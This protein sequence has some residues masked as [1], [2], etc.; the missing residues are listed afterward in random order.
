MLKVHFSI[1]GTVVKVIQMGEGRYLKIYLDES[2][3]DEEAHDSLNRWCKG[4]HHWWQLWRKKGCPWYCAVTGS[5]EEDDRLF[6]VLTQTREVAD[7][8]A[9]LLKLEHCG[10]DEC[11]HCSSIS[12]V[13]AEHANLP[14]ETP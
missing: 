12:A 8:L 2:M 11:F 10:D 5:V 4:R 3:S 14:K 9:R 1:L 6:E 13:L 7:K